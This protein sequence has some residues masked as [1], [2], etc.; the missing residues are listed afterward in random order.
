MLAGGTALGQ[1][2]KVLAS[3]ILTRLYKPED[4]GILGVYSSILGILSVIASL[5][6]ELA[7]PLPENDEDAANLL[8]LSLGIVALISLLISLGIRFWGEQIV[9]WANAPALRSYLWLL[10]LGVG[11]IGIYHVFNYWAVRKG[12]FGRIAR[13]KLNQGV[14]SVISQIGLGLLKL[15]P[16]GLLVGWIVGHAAGTGTLAV[17]ALREDKEA[18]ST[19]SFNRIRY[20][21]LRYRKFP[22][23]SSGAALLNAL[24]LQI[25]GLLLS[26]FYG[27]EVVGQFALVQRVLGMPL[28]LIG[29]SVSQVYLGRAAAQART[30]VQGLQRLFNSVAKRL[31]VLGALPTIALIIAGPSLFTLVFGKEWRE[32]GIYA[33]LMAPAFLGGFVTVPLSYTFSVLERQDLSVVWNASR[34]LFS[35]GSIYLA[36]RLQLGPIHAI[37]IYSLGMSAGYFN[38]FLLSRYAIRSR[39]RVRDMEV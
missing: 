22:L 13:T 9:R 39:T 35:V 14:S 32:A 33:Q 34:L 27:T 31:T 20:L 8:A 21:A 24:G 1:A 36:Y 37:A 15:G 11:M 19:I 2:I 16:F 17:S 6:Y 4:F 10:P 5:R 29:T 3:P 18:L 23:F 26:A 12:A 25:P 38:L 7:I 28:T 30:N